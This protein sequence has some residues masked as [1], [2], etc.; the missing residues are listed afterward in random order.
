M[1]RTGLV[2]QFQYTRHSGDDGREYKSE[3]PEGCPRNNPDAKDNADEPELDIV[4]YRE[5]TCADLEMKEYI[6][7]RSCWPICWRPGEYIRE[8]GVGW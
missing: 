3:D 4:R 1:P 5:L 6:A 7:V 2:R 8:G